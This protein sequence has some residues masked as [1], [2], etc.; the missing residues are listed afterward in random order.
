MLQVT[1]H[2][3]LVAHVGEQRLGSTG[4][5]RAAFVGADPP[6]RPPWRLIGGREGLFLEGKYQGDI[7]D[8]VVAASSGR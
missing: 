5:P 8:A 6:G 3:W 2:P 4:A 7:L 1:R